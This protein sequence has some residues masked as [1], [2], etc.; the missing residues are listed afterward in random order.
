MLYYNT[1]MSNVIYPDAPRVAVGAV[2]IY[3]NKVLLVLRGKAPAKDV[4]SIPG[5]AVDLGETLQAAAE[6]E[7]LEETG[8]HIKAG[9]IIYT[10]EAIQRDETGRVQYHYVILDLTADLID[11]TEDPVPADDARDVRW[12]E[13][14]KLTEVD[15][16]ISEATLTLLQKII[17]AN[18]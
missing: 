11:P 14:S 7:V 17:K 9:E 10:F 4:W 1:H 13:L 8:L 6:R 12:F 18:E 5:G 16:P 3:E 2:I 15:V